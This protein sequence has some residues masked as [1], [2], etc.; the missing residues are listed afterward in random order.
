MYQRYIVQDP[1][2]INQI[3]SLRMLIR[4]LYA[5]DVK[6]PLNMK[7]IHVDY[8]MGDFYT[9][10]INSGNFLIAQAITML[11]SSIF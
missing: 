9:N 3:F 2:R 4:Y 1:T 6:I 5:T 8:R 10:V 7:R 11:I